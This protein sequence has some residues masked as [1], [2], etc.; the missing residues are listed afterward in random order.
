LRRWCR[1]RRVRAIVLVLLV[2]VGLAWAAQSLREQ[3]HHFGVVEEGVLYRSG[4]PDEQG[5]RFLRDDCGIRTVIDLRG[6]RP[7]DTWSI[8]EE[9]F[10]E[11]NGIR[12]IRLPI[13][14]DRLTDEQLRV[15]VETVSDPKSR[16]VLVHC[17]HGKSRTG[18]VIAAWRIV[19]QGWSYKAAL[20]ESQE[21]KRDMNPGYAAYLRE[22]A[23]GQGWRPAAV[24]GVGTSAP[25]GY[26]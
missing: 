26:P 9:T 13:R 6:H 5:W 23:A 2:A 17:E 14:P 12:H 24:S 22:L 7:N 8:L 1:S 25:V 18:V 11:N 21:Y 15:I 20:A 16:P 4:Q 19:A 3:V 10:C